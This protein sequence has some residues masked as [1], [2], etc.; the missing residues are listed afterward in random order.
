MVVLDDLLGEYLLQS[1]YLVSE[2]AATIFLEEGNEERE[3]KHNFIKRNFD[4]W[5]FYYWMSSANRQ[6]DILYFIFSRQGFLACSFRFPSRERNCH[7]LCG[8]PKLRSLQL[9]S[10]S[11]LCT[12]ASLTNSQRTI[13]PLLPPQNRHGS[14]CDS[15]KNYSDNG[16]LFPSK[17]SAGR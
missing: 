6:C 1:F 12:L 10:A 4:I 3:E 5:T 14:S 17:A 2:F 16:P 13:G 9:P 8:T 7:F 11:P 15:S